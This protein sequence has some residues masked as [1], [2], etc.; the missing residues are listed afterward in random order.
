MVKGGRPFETRG[1]LGCNR[2]YFNERVLGFP[3]N[4]PY[5]PSEEE[6]EQIRE[7]LCGSIT[8]YQ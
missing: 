2:P 4:F 1:C 8:V 6:K 7:D 3:F 5:P